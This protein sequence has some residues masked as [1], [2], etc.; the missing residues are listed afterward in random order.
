MKSLVQFYSVRAIHWVP[1]KHSG[2]PMVEGMPEWPSSGRTRV[3]DLSRPMQPINLAVQLVPLDHRSAMLV[4]TNADRA[5]DGI[6]RW[7]DLRVRGTLSRIEYS[8]V[9][10][11]DGER[12]EVVH[13]HHDF[14]TPVEIG[15]RYPGFDLG[16]IRSRDALFIP[17]TMDVILD[18][19]VFGRVQGVQFIA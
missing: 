8:A 14:T 4:A 6:V 1:D 7:N 18:T 15:A 19:S 13:Y 17:Y 16:I 12:I 3:M 10:T 11:P 5:L 2:V 9:G